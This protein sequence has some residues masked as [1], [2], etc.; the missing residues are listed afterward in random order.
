MAFSKGIFILSTG[1]D[2]LSQLINCFVPVAQDIGKILKKLTEINATRKTWI[3]GVAWLRSA[4][5]WTERS[6]QN[7]LLW[8]RYTASCDHVIS[9]KVNVANCA[10]Y[11][12]TE[13]RG[14]LEDI[15]MNAPT[16]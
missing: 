2:T 10:D 8:T 14:D 12:S 15:D 3:D 4:R 6:C 5:R 7:K 16:L 1:H 13:G 11:V 9:N